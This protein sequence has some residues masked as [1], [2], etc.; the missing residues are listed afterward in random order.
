MKPFDEPSPPFQ[1]THW[2]VIAQAVDSNAPEFDQALDALCRT[3]W[4]PLYVFVRRSG[5]NPDD[6]KDLV[7]GFFEVL[8]ERRI[9]KVAD[10]D[11][12]RFRTFLLVS[13][14]NYLTDRRRKAMSQKRG[15]TAPHLSLD[16]SEAEHRYER[17]LIVSF[18]PDK[19]YDREWAAALY[20]K[21]FH[22][23]NAEYEAAG[24]N[25]RFELLSASLLDSGGD[26]PTHAEI[27][28]QLGMSES[29]VKSAAL[30]LR[31][32]FRELYRAEIV[33]LVE[34]PLE[35]DSEIRHLMDS[36]S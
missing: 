26:G 31:R 5:Y 19:S 13:L 6:A 30:R 34:N 1:T 36:L 14:K 25:R 10:R 22:R 8:L 9:H 12:G 21:V 17:E 3:Y 16:F 27:R 23:L 33:A 18:E 20:R 11:R 35:V 7:Q 29:A 32:R 4:Y 15:G 2:S 24:W 28:R